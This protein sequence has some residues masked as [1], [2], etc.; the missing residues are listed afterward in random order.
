MARLN[1]PTAL[2]MLLATSISCRTGSITPAQSHI[3]DQDS[4]SPPPTDTAP[5]H[6]SAADTGP[7]PTENVSGNRLGDVLWDETRILDFAI[8]LSDDS[9][10]QLLA[11]PFEYVEGRFIF[12]GYTWE[13]VGVR[14][15]G[16]GSWQ[17]IADKPSLKIKFDEYVDG[18]SFMDVSELTFNNMTSD[19]SMMH[20]RV[21]YRL[22][23]EFGVPASRAHHVNITLNGENYGLYT[24]VE[25]ATRSLIEQ[26]YNDQGTLWE[27]TSA[28]FEEAYVPYFSAKFGEDD[29]SILYQVSDI[30]AGNDT[31][32]LDKLSVPLDLEIFLEYWAMCIVTA[33]YDGY[34]YRY[35]GD[36]AYIYLDP[37]TLQLKFMPHGVD[38]TFIYA[39]TDPESGVVSR[40]GWKCL[41][42]DTCKE[43]WIRLM[44]DALDLADKIDIVTYFDQVQEQIRP[45]VESDTR[46]RYSTE[47]VWSCQDSMRA[48]LKQRRTQIESWYDYR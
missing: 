5:E 24:N 29:R 42:N 18:L 11:S 10:N 35:P 41:D 19:C 8:E 27:F 6:D 38:E 20:E 33:Q 23:R 28:E 47:T 48:M 12:D 22:W 9:Y 14:T 44:F 1:R 2:S 15:K 25:G 46:K 32:D 3:P 43:R 30:L 7:M 39:T 34:P 45:Y 4:G 37:D 40:L 21:A 16:N 17:S 26:W 13:P 36:D 31:V